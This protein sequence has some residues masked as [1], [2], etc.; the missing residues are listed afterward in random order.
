MKAKQDSHAEKCMQSPS[1]N[2]TILSHEAL[3]DNSCQFV[4]VTCIK[5]Q[6]YSTEITSFNKNV[7]LTIIPFV[8]NLECKK[9][10]PHQ[11]ATGS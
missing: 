10:M 11:A 7:Q 3:G 9:F 5:L 6:F 4:H 1:L 2:P 8:Q